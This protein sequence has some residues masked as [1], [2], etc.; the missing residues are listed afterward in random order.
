MPG[1]SGFHIDHNRNVITRAEFVAADKKSGMDLPELEKAIGA[2]HA[3]PMVS[4]RG[5]KV[6]VR[7]GFKGQVQRLIFE[8]I[9]DVPKTA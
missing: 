9:A 2:L 1:E 7:I 5:Y 8:E 4:K 6:T 3:Q